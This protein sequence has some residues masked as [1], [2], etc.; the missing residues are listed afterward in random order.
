MEKEDWQ[1]RLDTLEEDRASL[2]AKAATAESSL[3]HLEATS[4]VTAG[5]ERRFGSVSM[6]DQP[7]V[8]R[9]G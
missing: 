9:S 7:C 2:K 1:E 8:S 5:T 6:L 4:Q 3:H